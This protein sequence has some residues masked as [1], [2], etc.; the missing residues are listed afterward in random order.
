VKIICA[1]NLL[2]DGLSIVSKVASAKSTIPILECCLLVVDANGL[3]LTAKD[4]EMTIQTNFIESEVVEEGSIALDIKIFTDIVKG[5][6][7]PTIEITCDDKFLTV[8]RSG[9]SEFKILGMN[10]EEFPDIPNVPKNQ[11]Y[12]LPSISLKN[13]IR[14]TVFSVSTDATKPVLCGQLMDIAN[15]TLR[16]V[17]VDGFR[18]SMRQDKVDGSSSDNLKMIVPS[19]TMG[20]VGKLLSAD[21][22]AVINFYCTD[23]HLLFELD[24][25]IVVSNLIEGEYINY[26]NMLAGEVTTLIT[27]SRAELLE[28]VDR[29]TLISKDTKKNPVKF[30]ISD[31]VM[32]ITSNA[33]M[34]TSYE[35]LNVLQ[36]GPDLEIGFNPKYITDVMRALEGEKITISFSS[37]VSPCIIRVEDSEDYKYLVLP[38][39]LR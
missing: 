23:K 14:Q 25:C 36:D 17:S 13:M 39:R 12:S 9:K 15:D 2:A 28:S 21:G 19:K 16:V 27:V 8:I 1:K 5:L 3:K 34:G 26:E 38:L 35:E 33:E 32:A 30:K 7:G 24:S 18:I 10:P 11:A 29:A 20:E 4:S 37:S 31:S 6:P 22:D